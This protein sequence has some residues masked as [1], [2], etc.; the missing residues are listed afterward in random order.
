MSGGMK[1]AIGAQFWMDGAA[2]TVQEL[3]GG[4]VVLVDNDRVRRVSVSRL[5][6]DATALGSEASVAAD[7]LPVAVALGSVSAQ[8]RHDAEARSVH[9]REL[10]SASTPADRAALFRSKATELGVSVMTLRR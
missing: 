1:L 7:Q 8:V 10:A 9:I 4:A 5:A 6:V 3:V 2:W